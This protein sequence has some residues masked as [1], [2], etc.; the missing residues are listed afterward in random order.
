MKQEVRHLGRETVINILKSGR[1]E[2]CK[3][4][5][6]S[7]QG[8]RSARSSLLPPPLPELG[9]RDLRGVGRRGVQGTGTREQHKL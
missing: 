5:T 4:A 8:A 1:T 2:P 3:L 9:L 7:V 6:G